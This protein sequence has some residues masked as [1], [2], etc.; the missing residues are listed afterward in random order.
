MIP[1]DKKKPGW[2]YGHSE[3]LNQDFA[4]RKD[5]LGNLE[6]YTEDKTHYTWDEIEIINEQGTIPLEVHLLKKAFK[7]KIVKDKSKKPADK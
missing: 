2:T 6:L 5:Y 1:E 7:G 3:V 4:F